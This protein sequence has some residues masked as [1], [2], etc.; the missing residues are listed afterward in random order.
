MRLQSIAEPLANIIIKITICKKIA[1][2]Y[3]N[4]SEPPVHENLKI[5]KTPNMASSKCRAAACRDC[6]CVK[7]HSACIP[8]AT[9]CLQSRQAAT[10]QPDEVRG[11]RKN[12]A[13]GV[14]LRHT[15]FQ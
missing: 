13:P 10:L 1:H 2:F 14:K 6:Q 15:V 7:N 12:G 5:R 9:T 11:I 3:Y 8:L 4:L